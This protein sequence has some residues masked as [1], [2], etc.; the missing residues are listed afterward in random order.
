MRSSP[1]AVLV[2]ALAVAGNAEALNE[3]IATLAMEA[4]MLRAVAERRMPLPRGTQR[5]AGEV[6]V[7][8]ALDLMLAV[9]R[10]VGEDD[11]GATVM[12]MSDGPLM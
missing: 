11:P 6:R 3:K 1:S 4:H 12:T 9:V 8:N 7:M 2:L 5:Q 10:H